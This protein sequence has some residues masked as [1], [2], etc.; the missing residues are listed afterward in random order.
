MRF[1]GCKSNL[2]QEIDNVIAENCPIQNGVFCDIFSG[3]GAVSRHFKPRYQIISNDIM[4]FSHII[5]AATIENNSIPLFVRLKKEGISDPLTFLE[6][7]PIQ[8]NHAGFIT[9]TYSPAGESGRMYFIEENAERI[10]FIRDTIERW[11][12]RGWLEQNEY[13]YLL[14][15]L[16]EGVPYVSN[17]TGT[18]GAFLKK[19]DRRAYKRFELQ[20]LSIS[21]NNRHNICYNEDANELIRKISGDILYIDPPYNS[22]QYLPNYH[23]LETIARNDH[24]VVTGITGVRDCSRQRSRYCSKSQVRA[25]FDDLISN[26]DFKHII[27]SYSDDG[28]LTIDELAE[29]LKA[30]CKENS[31]KIYKF[32]Y[33]RYKGKIQS[34]QSNHFEYILYARKKGDEVSPL[35]IISGKSRVMPDSKK[36]F[37]KSPM[38]YIGGKY[39]LLPQ[40]FQFFPMEIDTFIDLFAGSFTVTANVNARRYLCN[41]INYKVVELVRTLCYADTEVILR[42]IHDK[43]KE[44]NLS[45]ENE[46]GFIAFRDFYNSNGNPIDLFTLSCFSFNYQFRFNN[47]LQYNNP[48]GRNRSQYSETTEKNL[49]LFMEELKKRQIEFYSRDF[50][51]ID[52]SGYGTGDF[53]YCDPPYLITTGS[54]NDGN[55]GFKDWGEQEEKA[56]LAWLDN[57]HDLGM[58]FALSN[59]L[60][61]NGK[62]NKILIDWSKKYNIHIIDSDYSNCNYQLKDKAKNDTVEVLITNY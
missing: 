18:Y 48:F 20:R 22:R 6:I 25:A 15:C 44:Y 37:I 52:I 47:Q 36:R 32:A 40:L 31:V 10:D 16:I 45:K 11:N 9:Q 43:I 26:A 1:I 19:W 46:Q 8:A 27:V 60:Q 62:E 2:L 42:R 57:A 35:P 50:Q 23:V 33:S 61:H 34:N 28:L 51:K 17:I 41:D 3:T 53:V 21:N 7:A 38:N 58:K 14:A 24:P 13:K 54:Y 55:R 4:Y 30:H 12:E 29:I 5:T 49:I 56:L 59:M 39:K